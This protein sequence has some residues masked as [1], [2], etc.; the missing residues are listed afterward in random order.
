MHTDCDGLDLDSL[1]DVSIGEVINVL[2]LKDILAA[3]GVD[4]GSTACSMQ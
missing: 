4:K 1:F 3:E 2:V